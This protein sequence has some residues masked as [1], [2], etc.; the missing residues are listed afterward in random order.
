MDWSLLGF[1]GLRQMANSHPVFVHFPIALFPTALLFYLL[2]I[3]RKRIEFSR[4]GQICLILGLAG[5]TATVLSGYFAQETF[6]HGETIHHMMETHRSVGFIILALTGILT[7]WS[8]LRHEGQPRLS[9]LFLVMLIL[10]VLAI[11]QNS[12]LGGRMV[13]VEGAAVKAVPHPEAES[14]HE[15]GESESEAPKTVPNHDHHHGHDHPH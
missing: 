7:V 11:F 6:P 12:D 8:F 10:N 15:H 5:T 2:G 3:F 4:A 1:Q 13:Y 14:P 9:K